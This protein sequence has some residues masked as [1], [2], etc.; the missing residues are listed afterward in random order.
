M[1]SRSKK[2]WLAPHAL[3]HWSGPDVRKKLA[4]EAVRRTVPP[5]TA[6]AMY[7]NLP[8]TTRGTSTAQQNKVRK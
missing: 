8:S 1:A 6:Q 3:W 2:R 5:T 7:P 4:E